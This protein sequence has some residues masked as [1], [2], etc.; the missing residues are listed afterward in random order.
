MRG[1][2]SAKAVRDDLVPLGVLGS[3]SADGFGFVVVPAGVM[4]A[5]PA[6]LAGFSSRVVRASC[7]QACPERAETSTGRRQEETARA[8][9]RR[10]PLQ[11]RALTK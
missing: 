5:C 2:G 10:T 7:F 11:R 6:S 4:L 8:A 9:T 3:A 1:S